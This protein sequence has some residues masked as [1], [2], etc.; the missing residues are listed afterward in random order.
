MNLGVKNFMEIALSQ[1]CFRDKCVFVFYT[2]I[3][4]GR[5]KWRENNLWQKVTDDSA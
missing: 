2:E 5:Q 4:D 1:H 3:Q